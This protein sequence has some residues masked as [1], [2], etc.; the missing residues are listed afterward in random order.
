MKKCLECDN[1]VFGKGYCKYHQYL[2]TDVKKKIKPVSDK[3]RAQNKEYSV[4]RKK[5][6]E[7]AVINKNDICFMCGKKISSNFDWHHLDG[8][9]EDNLLNDEFIVFTH[10]QCHMAIHNLPVHMLLRFKWYEQFLERLKIKSLLLY[11]REY[12]KRYK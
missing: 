12:E 1:P 9:E 3:R 7:E 2:R 5:A 4:I 11:E 10:H 6:Y 8:R